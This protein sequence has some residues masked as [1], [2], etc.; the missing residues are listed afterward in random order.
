ML[1]TIL[2]VKVN[3]NRV[4]IAT[5]LRNLG[6]TLFVNVLLGVHMDIHLLLSHLS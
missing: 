4:C 6:F 1:E 2:A 3:R 5:P